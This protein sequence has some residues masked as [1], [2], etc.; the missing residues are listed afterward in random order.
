MFSHRFRY[1][2]ILV[3]GVYS[4]INTV[5]SETF[6]Y[7]GIHQHPVKIL[8]SF[9]L[10]C[11]LVWEGNRL[12]SRMIEKRLHSGSLRIHPLVIFFILSHVSTLAAALIAWLIISF[13]APDMQAQSPIAVKLIFV[14]SF[15]INLFLNCL[16]AIV[17]LLRQ[18]KQKELETEELKHISSQAQLQAIRNQINP[19]FLF[20]NLNVLSS[21]IL[22]KNEEAGTFIEKFSAVYRY[23]LK[24]QDTELITLNSELEF[25]QPYIFLLEKRFGEGLKIIVNIPEQFRGYYIVPVALQIVIE[26][27]LK[28]NVVSAKKPLKI[29]ISVNNEGLLIVENNLQLKEKKESS[30]QIGL[31]NIHQR[32]HL[33]AGRELGIEQTD[34]H[35]RVSIPLIKVDNAEKH[36]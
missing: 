5:F 23:I 8:V 26:N 4:Y 27:A 1:G 3:L 21:L 25:I 29:C 11:L 34:S 22:L 32:L 36:L 15:R 13:M 2:F 35:F 20:N 16:H 17:H 30:G 12:L 19:H 9:I 6:A 18:Y 33:V 28:H 24:N 31:R 14:F 7:Y 10:I